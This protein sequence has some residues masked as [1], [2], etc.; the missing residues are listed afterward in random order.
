MYNQQF[1]EVRLDVPEVSIEELEAR[2]HEVFRTYRPQVPFIRRPDGVYLMLRAKDMAALYDESKARQLETEYLVSR[3]VTSGPLWDMFSNGM[4]TS[5]GQAHRSRRSPVART[6]SYRMVEGL[7]AQIKETVN[8]ALDAHASE[9]GFDLRDDYASRIPAMTIAGVLGLA[10]EDI[11]HFTELVYSLARI[12]TGAW[13][14]SELPQIE[15]AATELITYTQEQIDRRR[16][17]PGDDFISNYL[18]SVDEANDLSALE[19]VMQ[20]VTLIIGGSDTTRAAIVIQ[21]ALLLQHPEQWQLLLEDPG[22]IPNAVA[23]ALRYEPSVGSVTRITTN[24]LVFDGYLLPRFSIVSLMLA[25][26]MRDPE[27]HDEPDRFDIRRAPVKWHPIF[28]GGPHRCLGEAL[29]KIELEEALRAL[30]DRFPSL[31]LDSD[32]APLTVTGHAGIRR[33]S[34]VPVKFS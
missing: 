15:Q 19:I 9:G 24:D 29:A 30:L 34:S 10:R 7:R 25:S 12:L 14:T 31:A 1:T 16:S 32:F 2:P 27:L 8:A 26:G 33:V 22:Y 18:I 21:T 4:L 23:E 3:G 20:L 28:G 11:P 6:F 5:N 13:L 17:E